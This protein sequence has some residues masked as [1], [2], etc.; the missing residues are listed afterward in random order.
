M[1]IAHKREKD[2]EG[3]RK[4]ILDKAAQLSITNGVQ[5]VT[6]QA[7]ADAAS[8][9]K[10]GLM[11]HFPTKNALFDAL[12]TELADYWEAELERHISTHI[13]EFGVF[14]RAYVEVTIPHP[15]NAYENAYSYLALA[16]TGSVETR[17]YLSERIQNLL[18][19]HKETD[20]FIELAIIRY[21]AEGFRLS[22]LNNNDSR[23]S[24]AL[25]QYLLKLVDDL[26]LNMA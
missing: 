21:A 13:G 24:I 18:E 11:H 3:V 5:A 8:V 6:I 16:A 17:Y 22:V 1:S 12:F 26:S 14:T 23:S 7:V 9:T 19:K 20:D 2:P 10:G 25:K 4:A 15:A